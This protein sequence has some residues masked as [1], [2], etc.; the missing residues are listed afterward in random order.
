MEFPWNDEIQFSET[1]VF[2]CVVIVFWDENRLANYKYMG[3]AND[4]RSLDTQTIPIIALTQMT[5]QMKGCHLGIYLI[6]IGHQHME[7]CNTQN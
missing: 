4:F 6:E 7:F 2:L 1:S 5:I 3:E